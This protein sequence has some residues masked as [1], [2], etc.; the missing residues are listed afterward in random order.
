MST[1][2]VT[3]GLDSTWVAVQEIRNGVNERC[4]ILLEPTARSFCILVNGVE[5]PSTV[6]DNYQCRQDCHKSDLHRW[7]ANQGWF[8][9][10]YK[11][12][13]LDRWTQFHVPKRFTS[14]VDSRRRS[15]GGPSVKPRCSGRFCTFGQVTASEKD[16][17][18]GMTARGVL[19]GQQCERIDLLQ[20]QFCRG[21]V[22][23]QVHTLD[24]E[25][26]PVGAQHSL[27]Q[28][29]SD[30]LDK[31]RTR[32]GPGADSP[33]TSPYLRLEQ[34][35]NHRRP[36]QRLVFVIVSLLRALSAESRIAQLNRVQQASPFA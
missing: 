31:P 8:N 18:A 30:S 23:L 7:Q 35:K 9:K 32:F 20:R 26:K 3:G 5:T 6:P 33:A 27:D 1:R 22:K 12:C 19:Q 14:F 24:W 10:K 16:A 29:I 17:A 13:R 34:D 11:I 4:G 21:P 25:F 28:T 2:N 15:V 36:M